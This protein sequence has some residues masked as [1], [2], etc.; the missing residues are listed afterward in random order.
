MGVVYHSNYL[1]WCEIGRTE[2]LR[3][4][5]SDYA[6]IERGGTALAVAE[7]SLRY[8]A[9]ARY[10]DRIRVDTVLASVR[11]RVITF[12]Y[13]ITNAE[14]GERLVSASTSLVVLDRDGR[15]QALPPDLRKL[16]EGDA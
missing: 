6:S 3:T 7:A 2:H 16:L 15:P 8:H 14:T 1:I 10:D 12:E 11:S 9:P 13:V 5:G 4:L